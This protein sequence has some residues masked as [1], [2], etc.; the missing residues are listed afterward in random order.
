MAGASTAVT[1]PAVVHRYL[2][3]VEGVRHVPASGP[4]V[5]V[6]NHNSFADHLVLDAL[7]TVF[8]DAPTFY[9]TKAESFTH[10]LRSRWTEGMGGIPVDRDRPGRELLA[11]VDR[12]FGSGSA[13]VVYPEGTRGPGWPLLPFKDGAFRFADR[14]G[15]PVIPVGMWGNQDILPKGAVVPR[16]AKARVVFGPP[17]AVDPALPRP[18]RIAAIAEAAREAVVRLTE[19]ARNPTPDRDREAAQQLA[20]RAEAAL[21]TML[22]RAD[23]L[24]AAHRKKQARILLGLARRADPDNLDALVTRARLAGLRAMDAPAPLRPALLRSVRRPAEQALTIDPD[25]VM[26]RYVL[27]RWHLMTPRPLGGRTEEG[28]VHLREAARLGAADTRFPMAYA[29]ALMAGGRDDE[30]AHVLRGVLDSPAPDLRT[31][32]RRRRAAA[33]YSA[34]AVADGPTSPVRG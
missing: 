1:R 31:A 13:L 14:G 30:A 24:P 11:S 26:A 15:V 27:G 4:F 10:P 12:V 7:L 5:L 23:Q 34:L 3:G 20:E 6:P 28:V 19:A 22:S 17:L 29:E 16:R 9:L 33:H 32:D 18:R 21:E 8:R 2:A 25:H